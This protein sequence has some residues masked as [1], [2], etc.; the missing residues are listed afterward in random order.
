MSSWRMTCCRSSLAIRCHALPTNENERKLGYDSETCRLRP[1]VAECHHSWTTSHI[2]PYLDLYRSIPI[3]SILSN[4]P[5][6][7]PFESNFVRPPRY[8][9]SVRV[10]AGGEILD[11]FGFPVGDGSRLPRFLQTSADFCV[12]SLECS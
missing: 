8:T 6:S 1:N 3:L 12:F 9:A 5:L 7:L 4:P 11:A 2:W 10:L